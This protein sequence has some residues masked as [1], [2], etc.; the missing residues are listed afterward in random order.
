MHIEQLKYF[1][2][3]VEH[4]S[5]NSV[6]DTFFMTPQAINASLRK[7]E[8]EFDSPLLIRSNT[9]TSRDDICRMGK[10]FAESI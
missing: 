4:G 8:A 9:H 6:A 7:L 2:S 5:V 1:L 3:V 10:K